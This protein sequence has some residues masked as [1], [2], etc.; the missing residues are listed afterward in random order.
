MDDYLTKPLQPEKLIETIK[1]YLAKAQ[2]AQEAGP[3][4]AA[5]V[6]VPPL[7][8][9]PLLHRCSGRRDFA[10]KILAKFRGQSV[11]LLESLVKNAKE[12][13]PEAATRNAHTLKGMAAT[14]AAEPLKHAAA[15]AESLS[16]SQ[17]WEG[18][19]SQLGRLKQE[20]DECL[21]F[22]PSVMGAGAGLQ[23]VNAVERK[24]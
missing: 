14:V 20:L 1:S 3:A 22:I 15:L 17:D 8:F 16:A 4:A 23:S 21:A 5:G 11:E 7:D 24:Q 9:E 18:V 19:E 2:V 6:K 10:E 12:K 13:D